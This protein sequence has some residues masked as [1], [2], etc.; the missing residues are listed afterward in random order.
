M[1][2]W[3]D[4]RSFLAISRAGNLS[5]AARTLKVTQTTM[6]RRLDSLHARAGARLLERTPSGF[7]LTAAGERAI[8]HV[9]RMEEEALV[10][11][12]AIS[13]EDERIAGLVRITTVEAFGARVLIPI[14]ARLHGSHPQLEIEL[15]TD[16]RSYSLARREADLAV[17]LAEFE[18]HEVVVRRIGTMAFGLFGSRSY[19]DEHGQPDFASG[20][21]DHRVI[22]LLADQAE[23]PEARWLASETSQAS[24]ALRSN[25]REAHLRAA[26]EG[27]GIAC[28]PRYLAADSRL[29][30][31]SPSTAPI[32]RGIWLGV[33]RDLRH[34]RRLRLVMEALV[35]GLQEKTGA[36]KS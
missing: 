15:L 22:V 12:R 21:A 8:A 10:V 16:N 31:L 19:L 33:H 29:E 24:I 4:L 25:S 23:L 7:V 18:Q 13:G 34:V 9:E 30:E 20:A 28:L 6:G 26:V 5:A 3:D 27:L 17:R 32:E 2:G 1:L 35:N 14:L 36:P 11:E